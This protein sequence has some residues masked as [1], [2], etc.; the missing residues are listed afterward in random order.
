MNIYG[1]FLVCGGADAPALHWL[2]PAGIESLYKRDTLA[3]DSDKSRRLVMRCQF[4][5]DARYAFPAW[6]AECMATIAQHYAGDDADI[7]RGMAAALAL[8]RSMV[9]PDAAPATDTAPAPR[10]AS[11]PSG[12]R[13]VKAPRPA[14]QGG[15]GSGSFFSALGAR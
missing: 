3:G 4:G 9:R 8:G 1:T 13:T 5:A 15:S 12:G 14:P 7:V 6:S 10:A 11:G 2:D